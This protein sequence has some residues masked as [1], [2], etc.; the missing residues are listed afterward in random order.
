MK[1]DVSVIILA[2]NEQAHI[3]RCIKSVKSFA[4]EI[5]VIDSFSTDNTAE[6]AKSHGAFVYTN[7]WV[8]YS[9]Q[10]NWA[11]DNLPI[12][13]S[14]VMRLDADEYV[15]ADLS[16]EILRRLPH[17]DQKVT[18]IYLTRRMYWMGKWIR[19]GSYYP[20]SLLRIWRRGIGRCEQR[21]M[22]EHIFLKYGDTISLGGDIVDENFHGITS[23]TAKHNG[24]AT[25]EA[26]DLLSIKY[27]Q[28]SESSIDS[29]ISKHQSSR[30]RWLKVNLYSKLP[31]G[32]RAFMFFIYRYIIRLGFLDGRQGLIFHILQSFWYRYLVDV[33]I[34]EIETSMKKSGLNLE[35]V[36]LR[37][38]GIDIH[39][40]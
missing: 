30:K 39:A 37:D 36:L 27:G 1:K 18:G 4:S 14:W 5:F 38:H 34:F 7:R 26:V 15:M 21:W 32:M 2:Y 17:L 19:N 16:S 6:I 20:I 10:F 40:C 23:W 28:M 11:L 24:Y 22:D 8:N 35:Q 29:N 12:K 31:L 9:N 33:K 25:R 3:E 13:S